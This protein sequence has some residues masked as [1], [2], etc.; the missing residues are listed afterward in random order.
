MILFYAKE[1]IHKEVASAVAQARLFC[2]LAK[3]NN[4][5]TVFKSIQSLLIMHYHPRQRFIL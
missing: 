4:F 3:K 2:F 5:K 1:H